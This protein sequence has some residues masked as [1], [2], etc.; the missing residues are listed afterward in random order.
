MDEKKIRGREKK[1]MRER[2]ENEINKFINL[3]HPVP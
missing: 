2:E 1:K 3:D